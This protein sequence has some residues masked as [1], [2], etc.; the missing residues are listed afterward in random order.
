MQANRNIHLCEKKTTIY[1]V[2]RSKAPKCR[3]PVVT[4]IREKPA[5]LFYGVTQAPTLVPAIILR[6]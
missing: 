6:T 3:K 2:S 5:D 4:D 1:K